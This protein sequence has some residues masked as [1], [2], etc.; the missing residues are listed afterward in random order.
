MPEKYTAG[1]IIAVGSDIVSVR[2]IREVYQ[3][4]PRRFLE[5]HFAPPERRYALRAADPAERLAARWAAKEAFAKVWPDSLGWRDVWVDHEGKRP[6][7]QFAD[8]LAKEMARQGLRAHLSLSHEKGLAL[9][10]VVLER[11]TPPS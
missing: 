6:V 5:R 3:R 9:A 7:L 8:A 10:V 1:V 2:R 11:V 4:R